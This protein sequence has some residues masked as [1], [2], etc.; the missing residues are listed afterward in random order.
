M[1]LNCGY[2]WRKGSG[3]STWRRYLWLAHCCFVETAARGRLINNT[4]KSQTPLSSFEK[5]PLKGNK[6]TFMGGIKRSSICGRS[7]FKSWILFRVVTRDDIQYFMNWTDLNKTLA[8]S[9]L[10]VHLQLLGSPQFKMAA[11][12]D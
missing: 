7:K 1:C 4:I 12:A 5:V 8:K 6:I 9:S 3:L 2:K 10:D 11:R